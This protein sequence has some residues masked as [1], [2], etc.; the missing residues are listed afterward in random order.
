MF[1]L[2]WI[3]TGG[4]AG[5]GNDTTTLSIL[6]IQEI[7]N[8]FNSAAALSTLTFLLVF[9]VAFVFIKFLGASATGA[10]G[11]AKR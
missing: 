3:M 4:G 1:D 10:E 6:V 9:G 7:R 11:K 8:G 5:D 2:P